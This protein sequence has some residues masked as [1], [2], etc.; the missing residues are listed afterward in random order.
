M[1]RRT[2]ITLP[3]ALALCLAHAALAGGA[4]PG[5]YCPLPEKGEVPSCMAPARETYSGWFDA[6]ER[7]ALADADAAQVESAVAQGAASEHAYL[8]LSTLAYGYYQL[9]RREAD[10][11]EQDP[12]VAARLTRWNTLLESAYAA[13]PDDAAYR[14]AVRRA[15][16][17]LR[18]RAAIR[19]PC[20]D[21]KGAPA[22]CNSTEAVLRG[23]DAADEQLGIRGALDR[24]LR[25]LF[26]GSSA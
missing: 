10:R 19:L 1:H 2:G 25:R 3:L 7:G 11:P 20:Q 18:Q 22:D 12:A 8:A 14:A 21:A 4:E 6:L 24:L 16:E 13:S 5:A 9:A 23:L 26:G 17:D 15:A